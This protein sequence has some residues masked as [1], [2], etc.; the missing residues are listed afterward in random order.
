MD[1][2]R[3][4][5]AVLD[6]N[7][8]L[9]LNPG[10][11]FALG[12]RLH[13]QMSMCDWDRIEA[14][15]ADVLVKVARGEKVTPSWPLLAFSSTPGLQRRA[16]EI[17]TKEVANPET[18]RPDEL[19]LVTPQPGRKIRVGYFSSD[20]REHPVAFLF[21]GVIEAHD[22]QTF[23]VIGFSYGRNTG[24]AMRKRLEKAFD[25]F[26]D[27]ADKPDREICALA[28]QH[29]L[30]IAVDLVGYTT[31]SRP[32]IFALRAAPVQ[33]NFLGYP[34]TMGASFMDYIIA[35]TTV[36]PASSRE[37]YSEK[38]VH[39]PGSYQANDRARHVAEKVFTRAELGL[40][41]KGF[42]FCCFN[43]N[44]K[45]TPSVFNSWMRIMTTVPDSVLWLLADNA[46]VS[47]NLRKEAVAHGVAAER[48]VFAPRVGPAEHL[49]RHRAA[50]LFLDTLPYTAH[51]TASD[52]LWAGVPIVTCTAESFAARVAASLLKAVGLPELVTSSPNDYEALA[53]ALARDPSRLAALKQK[54]TENR[55]TAPLFDTVS[56]TR[57]LEAAFRQMQD[58][59]A[60]GLGP[61]HIVL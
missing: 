21:A 34:G 24:D 13:A 57:A 50:D 60:T 4:A 18:N 39:M 12:L 7:E 32:G 46:D 53:I 20:Y 30:D 61:D 1:L 47:I 40:P 38:V 37:Y 36:I 35:D 25:K 52:A 59:Q 5:E 2:K 28:R 15:T 8:V 6:Y 33:V 10:H 11:P 3:P 26:I 42:V 27:V 23:E 48:L 56:Y 41:E 54:L 29:N 22:R 55:M 58:R 9:R 14:R 19:G 16:A 49:A 45:I 43:N 31:Q 17:W 51:T 44:F